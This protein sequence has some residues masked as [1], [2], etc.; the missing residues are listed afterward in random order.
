MTRA[1]LIIEVM[2]WRAFARD[3]GFGP[4]QAAAAR[5]RLNHALLA[6]LFAVSLVAGGAGLAILVN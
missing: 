5:R 3:G 4:T 6:V 1:E 2:Q